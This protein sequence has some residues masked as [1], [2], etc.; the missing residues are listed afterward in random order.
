MYFNYI[1]SVEG[2]RLRFILTTDGVFFSGGLK[3]APNSE[4]FSGSVITVRNRDICAWI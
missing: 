1:R 3:L 4:R 2:I